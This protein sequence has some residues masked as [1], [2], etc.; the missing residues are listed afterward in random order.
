[1][2]E[3]RSQTEMADSAVKWRENAGDYLLKNGDKAWKYF[4]HS[5]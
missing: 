4:I 3:T 1:M 5:T 2:V